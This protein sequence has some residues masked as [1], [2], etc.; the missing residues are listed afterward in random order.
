MAD[1]GNL[2]EATIP[3]P[4]ERSS[5]ST[6]I[7]TN[8]VIASIL[9]LCCHS[10]WIAHKEISGALQGSLISDGIDFYRVNT[11]LDK[12]ADPNVNTKLDKHAAPKREVIDFEKQP[13]VVIGMKVHGHPGD[14]E[15]LKQTLCL[16]QVAYNNRTQYD[17]VVFTTIEMPLE[18]EKAIKDFVHPTQ[19]TVVRD[20]YLKRTLQEQFAELTQAQRDVLAQRCSVNTTEELGEQWFYRCRDG[21]HVM[22]LAYTW[23]S[24]FR[25]KQIWVHPALKD[26]K[27]MM[28]IDTDAFCTEMW[29][30]DPVATMI[31]NDLVI[32]FDNFP[33][34]ALGGA[35]IQRRIS[36]VFNTTLCNIGVDEQ[37]HLKR[38]L[39]DDCGDKTAVHQIHGFMHITNLDFYRSPIG[40]QWSE[41]LIGEGKFQRIYDDQIA[42]TVPAAIM[43]PER[44][45]DMR[46]NG[47]NLQIYHNFDMDGKE[48]QIAGFKNYWAK[49]GYNKFVEA[50]DICTPFIKFTGR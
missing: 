45:W 9:A 40:I 38:T 12:H 36:Q 30:V 14:S 5:K 19:L 37:G 32:L 46:S 2:S 10:I 1:I 47:L 3:P 21:R 27:Y 6:R 22:P 15:Q 13:G 34:G 39:G 28:W 23:M 24:E 35:E 20:D 33:A 43:A 41:S 16:L 50:Q 49:Q 26:Y 11:K 42:V 48:K 44:S 4:K 7:R 18:D 17:I 25:S 29:K 8:F 31:R